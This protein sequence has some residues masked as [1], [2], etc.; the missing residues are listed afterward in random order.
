[1][2]PQASSSKPRKQREH[3]PFITAAVWGS[4]ILAVVLLAGGGFYGFTYLAQKEKE[5]LNPP[6]TTKSKDKPSPASKPAAEASPSTDAETAAAESDAPV[7]KGPLARP[8]QSTAGKLVGKAQE[9]IAAREASGQVSGVDEVMEDA[10]PEGAAPR[11]PRAETP[12]AAVATTPAAPAAASVDAT[13][14][15]EP[16]ARPATPAVQTRPNPG[17]PFRTFVANMRVNGVFQGDPGRAFINGRMYHVGEVVDAPLGIRFTSL[18]PARK[19]LYFEDRTGAQ[20]GRR[21]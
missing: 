9:A 5:R 12:A 18:D 16:T 14:A 15:T 10:T 8:P 11:P 7:K 2:P 21:Y 3:S 6:S 1:M 4:G 20:M 19:T 13:G 17:A